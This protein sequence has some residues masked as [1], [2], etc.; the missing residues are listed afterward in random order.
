M[1]KDKENQKLLLDFYE[2][3]SNYF[4]EGKSKPQVISIFIAR[5]LEQEL[6]EMIA[7]QGMIWS[8][9]RDTY[10]KNKVKEATDEGLFAH[11]REAAYLIDESNSKE[12]IVAKFMALDMSQSLAEK[13]VALGAELLREIVKDQ[14]EGVMKRGLGIAGLGV[15]F[16]LGCYFYEAETS[17]YY[18]VGIGLVITGFWVYARG[19]KQTAARYPHWP[20]L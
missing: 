17:G 10:V 1:D 6:A 4:D 16:S 18:L 12:Q 2:E 8:G 20:S 7:S 5:G 15:A 19:A 14:K 3:A 11:T 9:S 13:I